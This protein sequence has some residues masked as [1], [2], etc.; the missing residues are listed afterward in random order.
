[1]LESEE[2]DISKLR[3]VLY[4]RK[5]T[6]DQKRQVRSIPDQ[7]SDC[8]EVTSRLKLN[9]IKPYFRETKSAK[10]P[11]IRPVYGKMIEDIKEGKYDAI[12]CWSPDRLA[13]NMLEAGELIDLIDQKIVKD[14]KFV[15][16]SFTPDPQGLMMLGMSFVLSKQYSDDLSQKITRGVRK[17]R[18][19]GKTATFKY[20]YVR[21]EDG[22]QKP[23]KRNFELV[24]EAWKMRHEGHSLEDIANFMNKSGYGRVVKR[25]KAVQKMTFKMLSKMFKDPFYYGLLCEGGEQI[26]LAEKYDFVPATTNDVFFYIQKMS[27]SKSPSFNKKRL[28]FYPLKGIVRCAFC[29]KNCVVAPS[30]GHGGTYLYYRCDNKPFCSTRRKRSIRAKFVFDFI[31]NFFVKNLNFDKSDYEFYI[32]SSKRLLKERQVQI[33]T[34]LA[35]ARAELGK[36]NQEQDGLILALGRLN[37]GTS[38][39]ERA[40]ENLNKIEGRKDSLENEIKDLE[41]LKTDPTSQIVSLE[42]FLNLVKNAANIVKSADQVEKDHI[43]RSIFLNLEVDEEKVANFRL[44]EPFET[45][46]KLKRF[47]SGGDGGN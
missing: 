24:K 26:N 44:K 15:S 7:I 29:H 41:N 35:T 20:G 8:E 32:S 46:L 22:Y 31:Y 12:L 3:Y 38:S 21:D 10:K 13:R 2:R 27:G 45:L 37:E 23:D 4:A 14:I 28:T 16:T 25:T 42:K 47:P 1:M 39:S 6:D 9:V 19:E 18:Q 17:S 43:C 33:N 5:S 34:Q 11:H 30:T 40:K 36:L